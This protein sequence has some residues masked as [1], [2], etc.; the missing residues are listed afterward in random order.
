MSNKPTL[1]L[2]KLGGEMYEFC[3]DLFPIFR[4]LT[5]DGVRQT[6]LAIKKHVPELQIVEVPSGTKCFDWTVPDEWVIRGDAW[7]ED[8]EGV[9]I[10]DIRDSNLHVVVY[11]QPVD[12]ILELD[13][14]QEHL[15]S[16]KEQPTAIPYVTS[17]YA[18][19][20]GFCLTHTARERLRPGRYR[21]RIDSELKP[22]S[23]T[24]G[25]LRLRGSTEE[26]VLLST[27][28]CH[29]SMANN[30]LSGPAVTTWLAKQ[31]S[32]DI[33]R[34]LSYRIIF[35]PETIGAIA[36]I[37]AHLEDMQ[38]K[39]IAGYVVTC[40]GDNNTF[41]YLSSRK[42]RTIADRAATHVLKH[43]HPNFISY[44]YLDRG[45]DERQYCS[46]GVDLPV[47]SVM[48]SKYGTYPEYH[49]SLDDLDY[50]SSDGLAGAF[51]VLSRCLQILEAN[52]TYRACNPCEPQLGKH[53]MYAPISTKKRSPATRTILN[54]LAYCDGNMDLLDIAEKINVPAWELA[55]YAQ[56]LVTKKLIAPI[57]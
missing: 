8:P 27:Y 18:K 30:E 2:V 20:W 44:S 9:R 26:E 7:V 23:L 43:L 12:E 38:R 50:I 56:Q 54:L 19:T 33:N 57:D 24:Y 17:Y 35:I 53:D 4:S 5:G 21:V 15:H 6:L 47:A 52:L 51:D 28:V 46:P 45:S 49:T 40:V 34:R 31:L 48:R 11:S 25:E 37:S 16:I 41:S 39:V 42:E 29:P 36:Y 1:D 22:G 14:L 13:Q 10:I 55:E 3:R 32:S